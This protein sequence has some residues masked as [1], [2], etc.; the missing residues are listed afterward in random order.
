MSLEGKSYGIMPYEKCF[1]IVKR[2]RLHFI[3][4]VI[5]PLKLCGCKGKVK[6]LRRKIWQ[7]IT[8]KQ[9]KKPLRNNV[10]KDFPLF[11]FTLKSLFYFWKNILLKYNIIPFELPF[12]SLSKTQAPF[13]KSTYILFKSIG[14]PL[15][16]NPHPLW[17]TKD[18]SWAQMFVLFEVV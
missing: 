12:P 16:I 3:R 7:R 15:E 18:T 5:T 8:K 9:N 11:I 2:I 10:L 17:V 13:L 14:T 1:F 6:R 4:N